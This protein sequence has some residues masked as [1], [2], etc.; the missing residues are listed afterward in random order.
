MLNDIAE[1][2]REGARLLPACEMVELS[3]R[4]YRRWTGSQLTKPDVAVYSLGYRG[5][6]RAVLLRFRPCAILCQVN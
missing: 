6:T 3:L 4:A 5:V 2:R 1:A